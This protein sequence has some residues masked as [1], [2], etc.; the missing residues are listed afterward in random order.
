MFVGNFSP[1]VQ[2]FVN[3][4]IVDFFVCPRPREQV[5][6]TQ[7]PMVIDK[8][9]IVNGMTTAILHEFGMKRFL[10]FNFKRGQEL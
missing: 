3:I 10:S 5:R 6:Y 4:F 9:F 1:P 8:S 7:T 2:N